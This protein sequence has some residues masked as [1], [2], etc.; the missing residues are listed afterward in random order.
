MGRTVVRCAGATLLL[1]AISAEA[2]AC[3]TRHFYNRSGQTY[4]IYFVGNS[5]CSIGKVNKSKECVIPPGQVADIHYPD[6]AP[7][8]EQKV[9]IA[10]GNHLFDVGT[11]TRPCYIQHQGR[12]GNVVLNDPA[13]G[14]IVGY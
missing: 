2:F 14:D 10:P 12:T 11:M 8:G 3:G 6:F 5:T 4:S 9:S 7:F 1:A 13:D